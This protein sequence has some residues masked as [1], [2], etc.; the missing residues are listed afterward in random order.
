MTEQEWLACIN[1]RPMLEFLQGKASERKMR[2]F[3]GACCR[4][5]WHLLTE[6]ADRDAIERIEQDDFAPEP[7]LHPAASEGSEVSRN[8]W[9]L[10]TGSHP[11]WEREQNASTVAAAAASLAAG[12]HAV[13][14]SDAAASAEA[15]EVALACTSAK[16]EITGNAIRL[17]AAL[18]WQSIWE[19][20]SAAAWNARSRVSYL[21]ALR[22]AN[23]KIKE[24]QAGLLKDIFGNQFRQLHVKRSWLLWNGGVVLDIARTISQQ[25]SFDMLTILADALEEAGC[26]DRDTLVHCRSGG[27]H[28]RGCWVIGILLDDE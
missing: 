20:A 18:T 7:V 9:A 3:A 27:D 12:L 8:L 19:D 4:R 28:V 1:P 26:T 10:Q 5:I 15:I 13:D 21:G 14:A 6:Q 24:E 16:G 11:N 23:R 17:E 2:L 22:A 25:R